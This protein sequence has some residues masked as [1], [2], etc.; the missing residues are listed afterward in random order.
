MVYIILGK[1][2][3]EIEAIAPCDILRRGGVSVSFAAVGNDR[4]VTGGHGI[5]LL[6]D[7]LVSEADIASAEAIMVPGGMGGVETIMADKTAMKFIAQAAK[8]GV[9]L[10]AICAGPSVLAKLDLI[11]GRD[12]TC[13]PGTENRMGRANC[14]TEK[15]VISESGLITARAPGSSVDFGLALLARLKDEKSAEKVRK[16]LVVY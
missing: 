2:F 9:L 8:A 3:E 12:I 11:D 10:T 6:A 5:T 13:Y 7:V 15:P 14:Q 16:A 1:G 4:A